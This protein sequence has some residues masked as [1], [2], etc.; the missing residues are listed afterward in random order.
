MKDRARQDPEIIAAA[1][2][3]MRAWS[4]RQEAAERARQS[5]RIEP[6]RERLGEY[7]TIS[8][9][10]GAGATEIAEQVGRALGWE[11]L[12][13]KLV[14]RVAEHSHLPR[15]VLELVDETEP[16]WAY[17]VLEAWLDPKIIPHERY[18]V[19][20][21]RVILDAARQGNV[22]LVGRGAHF[23][24]PRSQ[25]LAVR[26]IAS[27]K[28]RLRH[29]MDE[30]GLAEAEARRHMAE[31]DRGRR[32]FVMRFFHHDITDPHLYDLV[33]QADRFGV[34]GASEAVV[35]AYRKARGAPAEAFRPLA[36]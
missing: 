33:I 20:L 15:S 1:E 24:L 9:E 27:E 29:L 35:A 11:V 4:L 8:R 16:N 25:G 28:Y 5:R 30:H 19:C 21:T 36:R 31:V 6:P 2:R 12:D 23:L 17:D 34:D 14:D 7:I 22:V 13:K 18:V 32:D 26:I 10:A 3:R